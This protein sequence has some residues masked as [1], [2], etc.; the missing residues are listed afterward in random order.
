[1]LENKEEDTPEQLGERQSRV[2]TGKFINELRH[3]ARNRDGWK[4]FV[5]HTYV[6]DKNLAMMM[7]ESFKIGLKTGILF[8]PNA[9]SY[10]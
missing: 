10:Y 6:P 3:L 5:E 2:K 1:M 7:Q 9:I 4:S 8:E